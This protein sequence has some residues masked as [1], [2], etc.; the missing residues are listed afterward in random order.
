MLMDSNKIH[1]AIKNE[2]IHKCRS[3]Y[4]RINIFF[5]HSEVLLQHDDI[6]PQ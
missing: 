5:D 4:M 3:K 6:H 2:F 1:I